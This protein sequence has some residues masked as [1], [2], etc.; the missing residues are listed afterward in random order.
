[1]LSLS[2]GEKAC[3]LSVCACLYVKPMSA[4]LKDA[5]SSFPM[6]QAVVAAG[7]AP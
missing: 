4:Q 7:A 1:M 3:E 5:M 2:E 6:R